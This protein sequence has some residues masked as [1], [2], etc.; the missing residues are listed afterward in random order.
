M[1]PIWVQ[2]WVWMARSGRAGGKSSRGVGRGRLSGGLYADGVVGPE[3]GLAQG[4][5]GIGGAAICMYVA[6]NFVRI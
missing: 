1:S 3:P 4:G 6:E 2:M 5:G